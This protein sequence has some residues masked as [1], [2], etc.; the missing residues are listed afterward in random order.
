M[1]LQMSNEQFQE[2]LRAISTAKEQLPTAAMTTGGSFSKCTARFNGKRCPTTVDTFV[3]TVNIYKDVE[4][5]S[6]E[7]ALKGLPLLF[8]DSASIWWQGVKGEAKTW[9][10]A[11]ALIRAAFS[12]SK[13]AHQTYLEIFT[14][15]QDRNTPI[16]DFVC[17]KRALFAQLPENRHDENTQLD[18]VFGLLHIATRK[19]ISRDNVK[20]F[21][22]LLQKGREIEIINRETNDTK[23][24]QDQSKPPAASHNAGKTKVRCN[25]C[26]YR[27]HT[28]DECRKRVNK[29]TEV[30]DTTSTPNSSECSKDVITPQHSI[31]C[32]GC[33]KP[34]YFRSNCPICAHKKTDIATQ[35][36]NF[37][38]VN[39]LTTNVS[40]QVPTISVTVSGITGIAHIDTAAK[41]SVAGRHLYECL[42]QVPTV[43]FRRRQAT[44]TLADGLSQ[45]QNI[46][47]TTVDIQIRNRSFEI[48]FVVLPDAED[49]RTLLG[50]DFLEK[51]AM[52]LVIP[53]RS[54]YFADL[55][56]QI[57][58]FTPLTQGRTP[59]LVSRS[60][61]KI[62]H[63]QNAVRTKEDHTDLCSTEITRS[64]FL[65][66][67]SS[68]L[69]DEGESYQ[70]H[71]VDTTPEHLFAEGSNY[72][73]GA[74]NRI[75]QDAVPIY[76]YNPRI[77]ILAREEDW[78]S[79]ASM[80]HSGL[81]KLRT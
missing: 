38:S 37:Y 44:V 57:Y 12:P 50:I 6:D 13:P 47:T 23:P 29:D 73:P 9:C 72:S 5:I 75:F 3:T 18:M 60:P 42:R 62:D 59:E 54:W 28:M 40:T 24:K 79:V 56:N 58:E 22:D 66:L 43:M 14:E 19:E 36:I 8:T 67:Y 30:K 2:L 53:Q 61:S 63:N 17:R 32:Y 70:L 10:E 11:T 4:R 15:R 78:I 52:V 55:P 45:V 71:E 7:D 77:R 49:N 48:D 65:D 69:P 21:A 46:L 76:S 31:T 20:T 80:S 25:F 26:H 27:G 81:L 41:T 16:D 64:P 51:A 39:T 74:I 68:P 1:A 35:A 33:G 34:G